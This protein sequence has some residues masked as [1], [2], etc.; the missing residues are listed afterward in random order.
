MK[1]S[2]SHL[3]KHKSAFYLILL[4]LILVGLVGYTVFQNNSSKGNTAS[5]EKQFKDFESYAK[6]Y[7]VEEAY[8]K[9]KADYPG[10]DIIAHD[11]AHIIG[12]EAYKQKNR[13][14]IK[15]CDTRFN[16]GCYHGFIETYLADKGIGVLGEMESGCLD[17]GQVN[18]P[19][20]LHGIG[21]GVMAWNYYDLKKALS[22]CDRLPENSNIYCYDGTFM[23]RNRNLTEI[24]F[25]FNENNLNE[26]CTSLDEKYKGQC[27]RNQVYTWVGYFGS[28]DKVGQQCKKIESR[29]QETC[30]ENVGIQ[31]ALSVGEDAEK[32]KNLCLGLADSN[33]SDVCFQGA[34]D[35]LMFEGKSLEVSESLCSFVSN[36]GRPGCQFRFNQLREDYRARFGL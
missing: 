31:V 16:Y 27:Y 12:I 22:D 1:I 6:D 26:P 11:F 19:S 28:L 15:I 9:L 21:H 34:M 7:G 13:E 14:G 35:E 10:N 20:C 33:A 4:V 23:E 18:S 24:G 32:I 30:F 29:F 36:S 5:Q 17:L 3:F 8:K 2:A 25:V